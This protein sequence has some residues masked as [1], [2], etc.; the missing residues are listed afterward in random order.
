M[1][2]N[3]PLPGIAA[4]KDIM[5]LLAAGA[6]TITSAQVVRYGA[7]V[8]VQLTYSDTTVSYIKV[9]QG[10]VKIGGATN[11]F[12]SGTEVIWQA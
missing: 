12:G 7:D 4:Q 8:I 6:N 2:T 1:A 10:R 3:N 9:K 11:D 5:T